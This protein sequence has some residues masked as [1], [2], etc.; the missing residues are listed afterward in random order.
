[1]RPAAPSL[2]AARRRRPRCGAV[3]LARARPARAAARRRGPN[4]LLVTIDTLRADRLGC[5]GHARRGHAHARRARRARRALRRPPSR[6][7]RS[8]APSHASIL[9]GRTPLGHGVRDNGGYVLPARGQD[10]RPRSSGQAGYRT[11]A[12]V[13]GFPLDRRFGFDRG[14]DDL[15]RPPAARQRPRGARRTSSAP[16]TRR[17]TRRCAGSSGRGGAAAALLP[18][19]PLLRSRTRPTSRPATGRAV[20]RR[21]LRRRDRVR[22]RA[23]RAPARALERAGALERTARARDRGPRREPGRARRGHPRPLPLRLHAAGAVDH[24]RARRAARRASRRRSP[25]ASTCCRRCST[26]P[27][28]PSRRTSRAARCA[29]AAEGEAMADAPAYAESLYPRARVRLGAAARLA[30]RDAS[31]SSR[32]RGRSS[33][34]SRRT[35]ARR[36]TA[37]PQSRAPVEAL[38]RKLQAAL[39]RPRRRAPAGR[40]RGDRGAAGRARLPGR[41]PRAG[42]RPSTGRDPKDGV[43]L[44]PRLSRRHVGGAHGAGEGDPRAHA[45]VLAE[46]PGLL[47]GPPHAR[48]GLRGRRPARPTRSRELRRLEKD[49][50]LTAED[51]VVLG[52]NLRFAGRLEGGGARAR[53]HRQREPAVR[54]A[55]ALAGRGPHQGRRSTPRRRRPTSTC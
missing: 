15:R 16:P 27:A 13:S 46:D 2:G 8:P 17:P 24:G 23:A 36:R 47:D 1:M 51:A 41:R 30:H 42:R 9:T 34:T 37:S 12:F 26:T 29:A 52:D 20:P 21:A 44:V 14:F 31:S 53:A 18:V 50:A 11:A 32:R 45:R 55:L 48:R 22:G 4:V 43:G 49:G 7:C 35:P 28:C 33:T 6:T 39:A 38:R 10:A 40:R 25:A 19:G 54:A 5:Y 3:A